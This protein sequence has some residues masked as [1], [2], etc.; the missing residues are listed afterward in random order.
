[1][2]IVEGKN[3]NTKYA[4]FGPCV[5]A[6]SG[7]LTLIG[8]DR[9]RTGKGSKYPSNLDAK[10]RG[11]AQEHDELQDFAGLVPFPYCPL[12]IC[13]PQHHKYQG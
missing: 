3:L 10:H 2:H 5:L 12:A 1:M 9:K 11:K 6:Q 4:A 7:G 13:L 8:G